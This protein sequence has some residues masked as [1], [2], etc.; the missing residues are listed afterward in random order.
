MPVKKS[1]SR[2]LFISISLFLIIILL[3]VAGAIFWA[4]SDQGYNSLTKWAADKPIDSWQVRAYYGLF[5]KYPYTPQFSSNSSEDQKTP[6]PV[7]SRT[8]IATQINSQ[9]DKSL[10]RSGEEIKLNLD[11][12]SKR[13]F[14]DA[15]LYIYG[16]KDKYHDYTIFQTEVINLEKNKANNFNYPLSLPYCN[17]CSGVSEGDYPISIKIIDGDILIGDDQIVVSLRE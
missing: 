16:I 12:Q 1:T 13:D 5:K 2:I 15:T 7:Y 14:H 4:K 9:T 17:S 3:G 6:E 10:Y 8:D 11:I